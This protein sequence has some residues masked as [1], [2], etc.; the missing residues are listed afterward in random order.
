V[1]EEEPSAVNDEN[2]PQNDEIQPVDEEKNGS[3]VE[4]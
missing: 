1:E 2:S 3:V 4:P